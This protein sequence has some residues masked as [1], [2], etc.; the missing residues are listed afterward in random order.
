MTLG[1][2]APTASTSPRPQG[3]DE[4]EESGKGRREQRENQG[5][6]DPRVR[7]RTGSR[8]S[9]RRGLTLHPPCHVAGAGLT[10]P[11][12]KPTTRDALHPGRFLR[13]KRGPGAGQVGR[14]M[15]VLLSKRGGI[16][17]SGRCPYHPD[18]QGRPV[19]PG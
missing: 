14:G 13:N 5:G 11:H 19:P 9:I 16:L 8:K 12:Q 7:A 15:P 4:E 10:V 3:E 6:K 2:A 18:A 1:T 17:P